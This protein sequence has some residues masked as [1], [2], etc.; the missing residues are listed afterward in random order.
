MNTRQLTH[1]FSFHFPIHLSDLRDLFRF[2]HKPSYEASR[3]VERENSGLEEICFFKN[4]DEMEEY[5][6]S[7][8]N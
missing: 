3:E 4:S 6:I 2:S 1:H 8:Q 5:L 7:L